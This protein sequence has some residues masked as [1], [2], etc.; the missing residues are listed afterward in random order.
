MRAAGIFIILAWWLFHYG[1]VNLKFFTPA[2]IREKVLLFGHWAVVVYIG[3]YVFNTVL[4]FP[5]N[6]PIS[7]SAGL[8]FGPFWGTVIILV[9]AAIGTSLAFGIA[10]SLE[11]KFID[12]LIQG[13]WK[14]FNDKLAKN[15]FLTVLFLRMV[16]IVP[17][18]I[19]N[20]VC[21]LS[22]ISY[23]DFVSGT[24]LGMVPGAVMTAYFGGT[25]GTINSWRDL[26]SPNILIAVGILLLCVAIPAA[27]V[28]IRSRRQKSH[29]R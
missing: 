7:L 25:L 2:F 26:F 24:V 8:I 14:S 9:S 23:K 15:G 28:Y 3:I 21:G 20:Y 10:R 6:A 5:P 4:V 29:D 1:G 11:R 17:F 19:L 16:P 27:Y 22:R 18:E 13:K 12:R